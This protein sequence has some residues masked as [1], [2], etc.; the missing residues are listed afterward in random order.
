M[1]NVNEKPFCVTCGLNILNEVKAN[2]KQ[3]YWHEKNLPSDIVI[4]NANFYCSSCLKKHVRLQIEKEIDA[5]SYD[6]IKGKNKF[7]N[8]DFARELIDGID[9]D[10]IGEKI[11]FSRFYLVRRGYCCHNKCKNCPY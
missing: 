3:L 4:N 5:L 11:I 10:T 7:N 1:N 9:Y 8:I 2:D 6:D